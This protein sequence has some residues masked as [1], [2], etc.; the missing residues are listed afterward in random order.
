MTLP[1]SPP[2]AAG[3]PFRIRAADGVPLGGFLWRQEGGSPA[4][5]VV[6]IS[7]ATSVR[8]RYYERFARYLAAHGF[9]VV[10]YDYRG[11]GE[12]R[13]PS[14][15][16]FSADWADWGEHDLDAVLGHAR[17]C[18]PGE[19]IHVVGHSIGGFAIGLAASNRDISRILTVG[20]QFA[21]WRDYAAAARR[22]MVLKW[23][24]AM[25][26]L[27]RAFGYLP[28]KRLGWMEDT[29]AGV[30]RDWSRMGPRFEDTLRR[31]AARAGAP[32]AE[33]LRHRF[34]AVTA[35]ILAIGLDDDPH[36]TEA[37]IDR[38]LAYFTA[39]S[40]IHWRIAPA[41]AG[42]AAIGH[43]AFFHDRFK[44]SLWPL[45]LG[46]LRTGD[47]PSDAPGRAVSHAP[48]RATGGP[49]ALGVESGAPRD[50]DPSSAG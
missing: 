16:G 28:A 2:G 46:Y 17:A 33:L 25:P 48:P 39:S 49:P 41:D 6:V 5:A 38:L 36:G 20:A 14:L 44:D 12:S 42:H 11:I 4:G 21:Y 15:R 37:A 22:R 26:L 10:T 29:P 45:A 19:A 31:P 8:C 18:F 3:T 23:H 24:V 30:A 43:F 9:G 1:P 50:G 34:A 13:P 40:R 7:G 32:V 27:S 35:P 47:V